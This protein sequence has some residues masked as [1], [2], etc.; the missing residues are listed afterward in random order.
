MNRLTAT[1]AMLALALL[2]T[3]CAPAMVK[4]ESTPVKPQLPTPRPP[5]AT[6]LGN[7]VDTSAQAL[8]APVI[9]PVQLEEPEVLPV[10]SDALLASLDQGNHHPAIQSLLQ[11]AQAAREQDNLQAALTWLDQA[12]QIQPRNPDVLYRQAWV[13]ARAGQYADAEQ[14]LQRA[15]MFSMDN[16]LS[17]RI[18]LLRSDCLQQ[19]GREDEAE[20]ERREAARLDP[21]LVTG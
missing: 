1:G 19:L 18:A 12:R 3:G 2:V 5:L 13:L 20:S 15:R 8:A 14:L 10:W 4:T 7:R 9:E 21:A 11:K 6:D 16:S 17:A